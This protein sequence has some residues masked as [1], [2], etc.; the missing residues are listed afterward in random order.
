MFYLTMWW[1]YVRLLWRERMGASP[2]LKVLQQLQEAIRE[3]ENQ[4]WHHCPPGS[5]EGDHYDRLVVR[6]R[7]QEM[8]RGDRKER[9]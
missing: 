6:L 7:W 8:M 2:S 1:I 5:L 4:G 9:H 3:A